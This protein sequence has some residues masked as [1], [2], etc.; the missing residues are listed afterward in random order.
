MR[1]IQSGATADDVISMVLFARVV[2]ERSFT[3]AA[4]R[5]RL[6][7]S[8]VSGQIARFEERLGT[9]LLHRTTRRLSLTEAG[10]ELY[11]RCARIA[12]EADETAA[13][14]R[15][16]GRELQGTLRINAPVIFGAMHLVGALGDFRQLHPELQVELTVEDQLVDVAH[17]GFDLVIRIASRERLRDLS[18]TGRRLAIDQLIVVA[19]PSYLARHGR[20][21]TP[22]DLVHHHC[23]RYLQKTPHAEWRFE[24]SGAAAY[25]PVPSGFASNSGD[26]LRAAALAGMGLAILPSYMV[27]DALTSGALEAVLTDHKRDEL[28]IWAL[29]PSRRHVPGKVR[30]LVDF[31]A[32]RFRSGL[33]TPPRPPSE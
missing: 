13:L 12:A 32:A 17:G 3:A 20:P 7:K 30:A 9:R 27:V 6:S 11:E 25:V 33:G 14:A 22:D 19:A 29:Y 16:L 1:T 8:A 24:R 4:A 26:V 31:L 21:R 15:G 28:G 5:L 23:L 18:A 10:L 2:E